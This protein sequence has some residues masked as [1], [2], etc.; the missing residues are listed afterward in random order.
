MDMAGG[1]AVW[2]WG[3][4]YR[5]RPQPEPLSPETPYNSSK[6]AKKRCLLE[7]SGAGSKEEVFKAREG[8]RSQHRRTVEIKAPVAL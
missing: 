5:P 1:R 7:D 3:Q 6:R 2:S 8:G 4:T